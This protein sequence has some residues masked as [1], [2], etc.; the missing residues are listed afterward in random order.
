LTGFTVF[1]FFFFVFAFILLRA[2]ENVVKIY[3]P[4]RLDY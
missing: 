4:I 2:T 3:R 1:L